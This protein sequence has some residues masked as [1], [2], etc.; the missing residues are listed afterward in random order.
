MAKY[1]RFIGEESQNESPFTGR[2][3]TW[4]QGEVRQV[5]DAVANALVSSS[6][7][8]ELCRPADTTD[9]PTI[10]R[11][12]SG[13][14]QA[15]QV[16][17]ADWLSPLASGDGVASDGARVALAVWDAWEA[18]TVTLEPGGVY[19][20]DRP[21][22]M[23]AGQTLDGR[24]ATLRRAAQV[25][26]T[27]TTSIVANVTTTIVVADAAQFSI[28]SYAVLK[29]GSSNSGP[30]RKITNI[31]GTTITFANPISTVSMSGT[32]S[33]YSAWV[34]VIALERCTVR[35]VVF[36]GNVGGWISAWWEHTAEIN[37]LGSDVL[38]TG[39]KFFDLPGEGVIEGG[40]TVTDQKTGC[41]YI[42]NHFDTLGG[43]GFHF[44]GSI[45]TI[46]DSNVILRAHQD[47]TVGHVSGA[48][49][50]S[51]TC[52]H[53]RITNNY[54]DGAKYG[55]GQMA[56]WANR[57]AYIAGNAIKNC[58]SYGI[59][60]A[61]GANASADDLVVV[62]NQ[63][64]CTGSAV[65]IWIGASVT[66]AGGTVTG[67]LASG[68]NSVTSVDVPATLFIGASISGVGIPAGAY[69][70]SISG[71]TFEMA[72][73]AGTP[74]LATASGAQSITLV[75]SVQKNC[76]IARNIIATEVSGIKCERMESSQID[77]NIIDCA[78][79][80]TADSCIQVDTFVDNLSIVN[81]VLRY[82]GYGVRTSTSGSRGLRITDNACS[83]HHYSGV[84]LRG[85]TV[86]HHGALIANNVFTHDITHYGSY[87]EI[88]GG[89][90][91]TI[92]GNT[93]YET[94]PTPYGYSIY[95]SSPGVVARG[96]VVRGSYTWGTTIK[97]DTGATGYVITDNAVNKAIVDTPAVGVRV[98]NNDVIV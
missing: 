91:A 3:S 11:D 90:Y 9:V 93:I 5:S 85:G 43:N 92:H 7:G 65:P 12:A 27:T 34:S 42:G 70:G 50:F 8:W 15:V 98:A 66:P 4:W 56:G 96:N 62:D 51:D 73:R 54:I 57:G 32:T 64:Y 25:Q 72:D 22:V 89:A 97:V 80:G 88:E 60:A 78:A 83:N 95:L 40:T 49:G 41:R 39:C 13:I 24:G 74:V 86:P 26:T 87:S 82:G 75:G 17:G 18:A 71:A 55:I 68:T 44:S 28:G 35:D 94:G 6:A 59:Y 1:V 21:I 19:V 48:I 76:T 79:T 47:L 33:V 30:A 81:N 20:I 67:T 63:I 52:S 2:G 10:R 84:S 29:N 46:V 38:V 45:G 61:S 36:D 14:A 77:G 37:V 23:R 58:V 53:Q 31:V 69:I 16:D